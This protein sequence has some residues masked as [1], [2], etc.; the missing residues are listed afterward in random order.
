MSDKFNFPFGENALAKLTK[1]AKLDCKSVNGKDFELG[2]ATSPNEDLAKL[3]PVNLANGPQV[4]QVGWPSSNQQP[5]QDL[6]K[7]P[8]QLG[9]LG[10]SLDGE[11]ILAMLELS[12]FSF[13]VS[14]GKLLVTP[15]SL[16]AT[17][18]RAAIATNRDAI[19]RAIELR[20]MDAHVIWLSDTGALDTKPLD[21]PRKANG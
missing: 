18:Q 11:S 7:N 5:N 19:I 8:S 2:Q 13:R 1:L 12:G 21:F 6:C 4:G 3:E 16:L 20:E 10:Q 17:D 15:A 14:D 9:Q